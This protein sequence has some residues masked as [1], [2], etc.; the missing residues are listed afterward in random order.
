MTFVYFRRKE[1]SGSL[2]QL[3]TAIMLS[4]AR[5]F[6]RP[7]FSRSLAQRAAAI[8]TLPDLPYAYNVNWPL[9][10]KAQR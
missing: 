4:L 2:T 6:V 1:Y 10:F 5:S 3:E 7:T 8:H 9:K